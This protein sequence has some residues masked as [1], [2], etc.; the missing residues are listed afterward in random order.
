MYFFLERNKAGSLK[1]K[2][3]KKDG[4]CCC[5]CAC[6]VCGAAPAWRELPGIYKPGEKEPVAVGRIA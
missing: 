1:R 6:S 5:V 2:G 3:L 4:A